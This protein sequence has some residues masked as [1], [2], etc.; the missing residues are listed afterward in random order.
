M[1]VFLP[2]AGFVIPKDNIPG[3][4]IWIY[5]ILPVSWNVRCLSINEM[6]SPRWNQIVP[7]GQE[8]LEEFDIY[9]DRKWIWIGVGYLWGSALFY[10][11]TSSVLVRYRYPLAG[12]PITD[13]DDDAKEEKMEMNE[14]ALL[15]KTR[16]SKNV[17]GSQMES[18]C[19]DR[20]SLFCKNISYSVTRFVKNSNGQRT[21]EELKLLN[22]ISFYALPGTSTALMGGSGA[23]KTTLMDAV[24]GRKTQGS[25]KGER[26]I[27]GKPLDESTWPSM[28]GYVEQ[29][30]LLD[31]FLTVKEAVAFSASLRL[32]KTSGGNIR[33]DVVRKSLDIVDLFDIQDRVIGDPL[34]G[35]SLEQ[36]KRTSIALELVARPSVI[37]MDEPTS[38]LSAS[39]A[40]IVVQTIKKLSRQATVVV[41]IHQPSISIFE[42][43]DQLLLLHKGGVVDYFGPIGISSKHILDYFGSF[44]EVRPIK[45]GY[46]PASWYVFLVV[47]CYVFCRVDSTDIY[48]LYRM[49]EVSGASRATVFGSSSI[50]FAEEYKKS[51]LFS[52]NSALMTQLL[53][54]H[55]ETSTVVAKERSSKFKTQIH[56]Q[57][58]H[59]LRKFIKVYWRNPDYSTCDLNS[60]GRILFN[61]IHILSSC[62]LY[63][64]I[65]EHDYC[66]H[67]RDNILESCVTVR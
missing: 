29:Y 55:S 45:D 35:L 1:S 62:R 31:P 24:L 11:L 12:L 54:S 27:N 65:H 53:E 3:Y 49:L 59:L 22:D 17:P 43:F 60:F 18:F 6:T 67:I 26:L 28:H 50:N 13:D 32:G 66:S 34:N 36:R 41:T 5:W 25:L 23:G 20:V 64:V 30:D 19:N 2:A 51:S 40:H 42:S 7:S 52:E 4:I 56:V 46:N 57:M 16:S 39:G 37:F 8:Q 33:T 9:S 15:E 47:L 10:N 61:Y 63:A 38:G 58:Y 48:T 44:P 14:V 21:E